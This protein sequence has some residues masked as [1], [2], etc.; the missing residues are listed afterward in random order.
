[1]CIYIYI[2]ICIYICGL[3]KS[4]IFLLKHSA[5]SGC[6]V[7]SD[8]R[9]FLADE[10][11]GGGNHRCMMTIYIYMHRYMYIYIYMCVCSFKVKTYVSMAM[12]TN[13]RIGLPRIWV[14]YQYTPIRSWRFRVFGFSTWKTWKNFTFRK[15][16]QCIWYPFKFVLQNI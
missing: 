2:C 16:G 7:H 4:C 14:V 3:F 9:G 10:S 11:A 5:A 15:C 8:L 1:M 12:A 6:G 13:D